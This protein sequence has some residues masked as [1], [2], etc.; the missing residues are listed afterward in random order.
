MSEDKDKITFEI[1]ET[2]ICSKIVHLDVRDG[3]EYDDYVSE[4]EEMI[5]IGPHLRRI[6]LKDGWVAIEDDTSFEQ[7]S[8][9][10]GYKTDGVYGVK[11]NKRENELR[12]K[13]KARW[14]GETTCSCLFN[15]VDDNRCMVKEKVNE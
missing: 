7:V 3:W 4:M 15:P 10:I 2:H 12:D 6:D 5:D 11:I 13:E 8:R 9:T 1:T 14:S